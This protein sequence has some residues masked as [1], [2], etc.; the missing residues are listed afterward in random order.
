MDLASK[1]VWDVLEDRGVTHLH[2]A[3][4]VLT[5]CQ[6]L[7]K[8]ALLSR[9]TVWDLGLQQTTQYSDEIDRRYSVWYDVWADGVDIH[10]RASRINKYG[11]VLFVL[12]LEK[13][14]TVGTGRIWVTKLN[15]T[16]WAGTNREDRWFQ[17]K[18]DLQDNYVYGTFE[19]MVVFR[20]CGGV[21]PIDDC[22][23][24]IVLDEPNRDFEGFDLASTAYGALTLAMSDSG[25]QVPVEIRE[26]AARCTCQ[27]HYGDRRNLTRTMEMFYPSANNE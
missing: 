7:R 25:L 5:S 6:F 13:L 20:H 8:K 22:L 9:G 12:S 1:Q 2:H 15:P 3:N 24:K 14:R 19:Q 17:S 4:S 27:A 26:C 23:E 16:N 21:L 18:Q 10:D 11:P